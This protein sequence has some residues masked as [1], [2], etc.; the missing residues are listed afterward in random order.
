MNSA[1]IQRSVFSSKINWLLLFIPISLAI[2]WLNLPK[3]WLFVTSAIAII[4]LAG[5]VSAATDQ[6][7]RRAG[8][9]LGGLVNASFGNVPELI[10]GLFALKAG[11]ISV[12]KASISGSILGNILLVLGASMFLGGL[13]RD[14]QTFMRT[15]TGQGSA[16]LFLAVIAL[17]MPAIFDLSVFGS[18]RGGIEVEDLSLIVAGVLLAI[19]IANIIFALTKG[20]S[21]TCGA[22]TEIEQPQ[23]SLRSSLL[24]LGV[25]TGFAAIESELLVDSI[26]AA[27][28]TLGMTEFFVGIIIVP[29]VGNAAEQFTAISM[30]MKDR[31]DLSVSIATG[32]S[33][34]VALLIVPLLV[35]ISVLVGHPLSLVFNPL[36]IVGLALSVIIVSLVS[37]DGESNWLEGLELLAVYVVLGIVFYF[38]PAK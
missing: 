37:L 17:V 35:F 21:P 2:N 32:A 28:R 3:M 33:T 12:V 19:Y 6:L 22:T 14:K 38:V 27:T 18:F 36:E 30:A 16:L 20:Y 23:V 31:M 9:G 11:L 24:L 8:P 25:A 4:P 1:T 10:I 5:L 7:A 15:T 29:L 26:S 34:Q 13:K